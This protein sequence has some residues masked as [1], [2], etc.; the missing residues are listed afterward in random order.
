MP[1]VPINPDGSPLFEA[2]RLFYAGSQATITLDKQ[3]SLATSLE[4]LIEN[5]PYNPSE[6]V[7]K[8]GYDTIEEMDR[9]TEIASVIGMKLEMRTSTPLIVEP[10]DPDDPFS[11][12][13]ADFVRWAF[14]NI[15]DMMK[16]ETRNIRNISKAY[17]HNAMEYGHAEAEIDYRVIGRGQYDG[18]IGWKNWAVRSSRYFD[19]RLDPHGDL[20][21]E[22]FT[23]EAPTLERIPLDIT[24]FMVY[25]HNSRN[26][27][28]YG[29]TDY[30]TVYLPWYIKKIVS[31]FQLFAMEKFGT[32]TPIGQYPKGFDETSK[33]VIAFKK[34]LATIQQATNITIPEGYKI[35]LLE[36][37]KQAGASGKSS[38]QA[39]IDSCNEDIRKGLLKFNREALININVGGYAQAKQIAQLFF[40]VLKSFGEDIA[41]LYK[42][43]PVTRLCVLNWGE[44]AYDYIPLL[45]FEKLL[46]EDKNNLVEMIE[47]LIDKQVV[48]PQEDWIREQLGLPARPEVITE[49]DDIV[50]GGTEITVE[51]DEP[52]PPI[53]P[54]AET[55]DQ[56]I[57]GEEVTPEG[58]Q[59]FAIG[60]TPRSYLSRFDY[61]KVEKQLDTLEDEGVRQASAYFIAMRDSLVEQV[62]RKK[63][64]ERK[65]YPDI[66][67]L[68]YSAGPLK[69]IIWNNARKVSISGIVDVAEE[70]KKAG[71]DVKQFGRRDFQVVFD[72]DIQTNQEALA[73]IMR[74]EP[75]FKNVEGNLVSALDGLTRMERSRAFTV[76]GIENKAVLSRAQ[77]LLQEVIELEG[78]VDDYERLLGDALVQ[79]T[80]DTSIGVAGEPIKPWHTRN[81]FRTNGSTFYNQGRDIWELTPVIE[82][83]EVSSV[84][85]DRTTEVCEMINGL[86]FPK[87]HSFWDTY[88]PP[89]HF[90]CRTVKIPI[91]IGEPIDL[92]QS[93]KDFRP[94]IQPQAGFSLSDM[95]GNT[96]LG[97]AVN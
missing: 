63:I 91:V 53:T 28:P 62:R 59:T 86:Q 52:K 1:N 90:Q 67:K 3:Q 61:K 55:P 89:N 88:T 46:E 11:V 16:M 41:N 22:G 76:A 69:K 17:M 96:G 31:S 5:T 42:T 38:Y 23:Q 73:T 44:K 10:S 30:L 19:F 60:D 50:G 70:I 78:N 93:V 32:P 13:V 37:A 80:G 75:A 64:I 94:S 87:T 9:D 85:D 8:K 34:V 35:E 33:E 25:A 57:E 14:Q 40:V 15:G 51:P 24:K 2:D 12:E 66:Q 92:A 20:M 26:G 39:V 7:D 43:Q 18:M 77:I 71:I 84:M 27:N 95:P 47:K 29:E 97:N 74:M 48:N 45:S 54:D 21:K 81:V 82:G 56:E 4:A 49:G 36:V 6:L 79:Y 65:A 72:T 68:A 58:K 83:W